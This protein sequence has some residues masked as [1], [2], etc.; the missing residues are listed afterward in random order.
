MKTET[1]GII[2]RGVGGFG[3]HQKIRASSQRPFFN[4]E[5][6]QKVIAVNHFNKGKEQQC[7]NHYG[8][9]IKTFTHFTSR[10]GSWQYHSGCRCFKYY[11]TVY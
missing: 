2:D 6:I 4:L 3:L 1:L 10:Y 9:F 7:G 8:H 5:P 11:S